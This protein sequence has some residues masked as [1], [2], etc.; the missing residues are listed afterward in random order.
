MKK[1]IIT[2]PSHL[3]NDEEFWNKAYTPYHETYKNL[4]ERGAYWI[5]NKKYKMIFLYSRNGNQRQF[6]DE[7]PIEDIYHCLLVRRKAEKLFEN[8]EVMICCKILY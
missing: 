3:K 4:A 6:F 8:D 7:D 5:V 1:F 2:I